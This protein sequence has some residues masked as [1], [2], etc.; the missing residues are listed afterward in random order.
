MWLNSMFFSSARGMFNFE[1]L[2]IIKKHK[3]FQIS[4]NLFI[5]QTAVKSLS[6]FLLEWEMFPSRH[7]SYFACGK[8][9]INLKSWLYFPVYILVHHVSFRFAQCIKF[10]N[11]LV[12]EWWC[13]CLHTYFRS[14]FTKCTISHV[15][16]ACDLTFM[17]NSVID[18]ISM[19]RKK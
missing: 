18:F 8:P 19:V 17:L 2:I 5:H 14:L 7:L 6:L 10:S 3:N 9:I 1:C 11:T 16:N 4:L 12:S 13:N 15:I